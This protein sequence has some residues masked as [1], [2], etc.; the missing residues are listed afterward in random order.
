MQQRNVSH[1]TVGIVA[2][3]YQVVIYGSKFEMYSKSLSVQ[4]T[5]FVNITLPT[6]SECQS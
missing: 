6:M 2:M 5:N 3:R 4:P 1:S